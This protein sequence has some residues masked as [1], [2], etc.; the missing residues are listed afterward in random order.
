MT[1]RIFALS[2]ALTDNIREDDVQVLVAAIKLLRGV[3]SVETH[4][5]D[6]TL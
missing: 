4:V 6:I 1:N 2:V 5:A 3:L